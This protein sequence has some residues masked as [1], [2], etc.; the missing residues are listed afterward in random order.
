MGSVYPDG[1]TGTDISEAWK[2]AYC[3]TEA[4]NYD[5]ACYGDDTFES[6]LGP[7]DPALRDLLEHD[8]SAED[9][10]AQLLRAEL[11]GDDRGSSQR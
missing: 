5:C 2:I 11:V 3:K 4:I 9:Q 6:D 7:V 10:C 8:W 1:G